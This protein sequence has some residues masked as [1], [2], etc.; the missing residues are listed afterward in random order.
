MNTTAANEQT[1]TKAGIHITAVRVLIW[2]TICN[3]FTDAFSLSDMEEAL[4]TVDRSTLFR[5]LTT[6]S[7]A[8]LLHRIS[9]G[10][11]VQKYCLCHESDTRHCSGH[12]HFT[13]SKCHRTFCLSEV[14]IPSVP[15][16]AGYVAEDAEYVVTGVCAECGRKQA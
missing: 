12:I 7:D 4:P 10:S 9:D 1:L 16:P 6:L 5:T 8:H 2:K 3:S 13:C 14:R 15:L 11:G